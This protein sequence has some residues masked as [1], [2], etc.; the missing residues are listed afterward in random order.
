MWYKKYLENQI[1]SKETKTLQKYFY[2]YNV[3]IL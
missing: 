1:K 2:I 3:S